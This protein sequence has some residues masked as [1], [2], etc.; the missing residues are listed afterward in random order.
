MTVEQCGVRCEQPEVNTMINGLFESKQTL[1]SAYLLVV[2]LSLQT[3]QI[4][5]QRRHTRG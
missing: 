2:N 3:E 1:K 4:S 5:N